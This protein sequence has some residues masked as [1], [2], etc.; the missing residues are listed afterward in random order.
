MG[1]GQLSTLSA[2]QSESGKA[3][4]S[5]CSTLDRKIELVRV[6]LRNLDPKVREAVLRFY[7]DRK[8]P[9]SIEEELGITPAELS[10]ARALVRASFRRYT[11]PDEAE[12]P[13][14]ALALWPEEHK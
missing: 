12:R 4:R 5:Q 14:G 2:W 8:T 6:L 10:A 9:Q 1:Q 13:A 3:R 11:R 7:V